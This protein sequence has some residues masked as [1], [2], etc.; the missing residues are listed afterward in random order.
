MEER[1]FKI[2][3]DYSQSLDEMI[4]AGEYDYV[5]EFVTEEKFPLPE[6]MIGTKTEL[7]LGLHCFDRQISFGEAILELEKSELRLATLPELLAFGAKYRQE[8]RRGGYIIAPGFVCQN[9]F[10]FKFVPY[11]GKI[12]INGRS[13]GL[14]ASGTRDLSDGSVSEWCQFL[15]VRRSYDRKSYDRQVTLIASYN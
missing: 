14:M 7:N 5:E 2:V 13:L 8:Q 9:W 10:G 6:S 15:V 4:N 3:V 12:D 11:L 1:V